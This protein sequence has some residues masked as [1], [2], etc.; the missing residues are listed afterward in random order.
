VVTWESYTYHKKTT[1]YVSNGIRQQR[2]DAD[3]DRVGAETAVGV[4]ADSDKWV[5]GQDDP[6]VTALADGGWVVTWVSSDADKMNDLLGSEIHQLR[7]NAHGKQIGLETRIQTANVPEDNDPSV[8]ALADGG[9]VVTWTDPGADLHQQR[10]AADGSAV[11]RD[12]TVSELTSGENDIPSGSSVSALADGGWVVTWDDGY[13]VSEQR[14]AANGRAVGPEMRVN[15]HTRGEERYP[16]VTGL[17]DGGWVVTWAAS[18][19]DGSGDGVY[20]RVFHAVDGTGAAEKLKG[21]SGDDFVQ[22]LGGNDRLFG[23]AG[24]DI[25]IGGKGAD[26][27]VFAPGDSGSTH[28]TADTIHNFAKIDHIDLSSWAHGKPFDAFDFIGTHAFT[29]HAGELRFVKEKSDTWIE[30][31]TDGNGKADLVIH[32][33]NAVT[34]TKD[35]FD[36]SAWS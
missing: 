24:H 8:S 31:D 25:L 23:N 29:G 35:Y 32:L 20:Q 34:M 21:A 1:N 3:G 22:G 5:D 18:H 27:F 19:Q 13:E 12:T 6:A 16:S 10:Y 4:R 14:Y 36:V 7:F 11:G 26:T 28:A 33:D 17:A 9:W 15:I 2:Y 30:G